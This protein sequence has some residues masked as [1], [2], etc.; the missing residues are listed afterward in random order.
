LGIGAMDQDQ[1]A[2]GQ[3]GNQAGGVAHQLEHE[4]DC[5]RIPSGRMEEDDGII[6]I[7]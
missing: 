2:L 1:R 4:V 5:Q 6:C 7:H 3:I